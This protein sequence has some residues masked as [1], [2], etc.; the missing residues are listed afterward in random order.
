MA[1]DEDREEQSRQELLKLL[2]EFFKHITTLGGAAAVVLLAV[3]REGIAER[4]LLPSSLVML[5]CGVFA[6]ILGMVLAVG[7]FR[8][9]SAAGQ[10][11]LAMLAV[12]IALVAGGFIVFIAQI[13][14]IPS[15]VLVI[16]L[17]VIAAALVYVRYTGRTF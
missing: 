5:G 13:L 11:D 12:A 10:L 3:Y 7:R 4:E 9:G 16:A 8:K 15:W 2:F 14:N 6:A 17:I 1:V